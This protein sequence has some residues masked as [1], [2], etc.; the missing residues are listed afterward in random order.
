MGKKKPTL[1]GVTGPYPQPGASSVA[2][3]V[4]KPGETL[5]PCS[6]ALFFPYSRS[7]TAC[8]PKNRRQLAFDAFLGIMIRS[9]N[10]MIGMD[11]GKIRNPLNALD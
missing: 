11:V 4:K 9:P 6:T 7:L 1:I 3:P 10:K 2:N 5:E 8:I